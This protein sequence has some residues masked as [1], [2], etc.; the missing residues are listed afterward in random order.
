MDETLKQDI[1][2]TKQNIALILILTILML[3]VY[4]FILIVFAIDIGNLKSDM[5]QRNL[6]VYEDGSYIV[7]VNDKKLYGCLSKQPCQD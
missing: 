4:G 5:S 6:R 1:K 7:E 2:K 3:I